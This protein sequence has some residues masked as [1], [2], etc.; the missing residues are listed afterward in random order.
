MKN[1]LL[2]QSLV[3]LLSISFTILT[4]LM[5]PILSEPA[6]A[7]QF[8]KGDLKGSLDSTISYGLRWR[9]QGRD[10]DI[11]GL[12]NGGNAYSV[13]GDN[14]NLNFD[15]GLVSNTPKITSDLELDYKNFGAFVRGSAFYDFK[16]E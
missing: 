13:N 2:N 4:T 9:V 14:G 15:T 8:E 11:I 12:T 5:I 3:W 16:V 10:K 7:M 6:F 1:R